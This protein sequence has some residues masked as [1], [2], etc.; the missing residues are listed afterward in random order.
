ML[1]WRII[2]YS[3]FL[4]L[5]TAGKAIPITEILKAHRTYDLYHAYRLYNIE[6]AKE[7]LEVAFKDQLLCT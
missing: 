2:N 5:K 4:D 7:E 6:F 1:S 3:S